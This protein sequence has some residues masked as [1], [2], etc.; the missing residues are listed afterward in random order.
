MAGHFW[1]AHAL[2]LPPRG[3]MYAD[4][5]E[6]TRTEGK[7]EWGRGGNAICNGAGNRAKM[8]GVTVDR[9][10]MGGRNG[11]GG[12]RRGRNERPAVTHADLDAELDAFL[13]EKD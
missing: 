3:T 11:R 1:N 6:D 9:G 2:E 10:I 8:A 12:E 13:E 5:L 4:M 7:L